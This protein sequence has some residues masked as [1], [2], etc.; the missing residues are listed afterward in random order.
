MKIILNGYKNTSGYWTYNLLEL[1]NTYS[2]YEV[3][4]PKVI[5]AFSTCCQNS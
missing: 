5:L 4:N 2:L 3:F 1:D